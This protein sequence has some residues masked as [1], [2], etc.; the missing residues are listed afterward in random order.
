MS[1]ETKC[2]VKFCSLI[3]TDNQCK[4]CPDWDVNWKHKDMVIISY[5]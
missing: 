4:N 3:G 2:N 1:V 5:G